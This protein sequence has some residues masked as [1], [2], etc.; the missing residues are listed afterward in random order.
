MAKDKAF[1]NFSSEAVRMF[2]SGI[3][4]EEALRQADVFGGTDLKMRSMARGAVSTAYSWAGNVDV[5]GNVQAL[6]A[7]VLVQAKG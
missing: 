7:P 4:I 1:D 6:E 5:F 2:E 3:P